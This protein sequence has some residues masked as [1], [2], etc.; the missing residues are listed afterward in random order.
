M[1]NKKSANM[2][3]GETTET[4]RYVNILPTVLSVWHSP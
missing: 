3:I 1:G 4:L 2:V